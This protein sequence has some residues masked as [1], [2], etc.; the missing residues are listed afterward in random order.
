MNQKD[1][2]KSRAYECPFLI[3]AQDSQLQSNN[4]WAGRLLHEW[5]L[6][7][8]T[9]EATSHPS[10]RRGALKIGEDT[11]VQDLLSRHT[12][13]ATILDFVA[14]QFNVR[15][16]AKDIYNLQISRGNM[17]ISG[18]TTVQWLVNTL[19]QQE[20]FFRYS[21]AIQLLKILTVLPSS[22]WPIQNR[23]KFFPCPR[24]FCL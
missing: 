4:S 16:V 17:D 23:F 1:D 15:L 14:T 13:V 2:S 10:H 8:A 9:I 11:F 6:H 20:Y 19:K 18:T 24:I 22:F 3:E 7:P 21:T 5:H 12:P